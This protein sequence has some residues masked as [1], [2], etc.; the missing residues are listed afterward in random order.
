MVD[1]SKPPKPHEVAL[2]LRPIPVSLTSGFS[3]NMKSATLAFRELIVP[4]NQSMGIYHMVKQGDHLPPSN[5][6]SALHALLL[7]YLKA[8]HP[9]SVISGS[10]T[11]KN[12]HFQKMIN[13]ILKQGLKMSQR[14]YPLALKAG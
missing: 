8:T 7:R 5:L 6:F 9:S 13:L 1:V 10:L 2:N 11:Q 12:R 4:L 14:N 3:S